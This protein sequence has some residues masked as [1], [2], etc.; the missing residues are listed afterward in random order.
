MK[1]RYTR[2]RGWVAGGC[3]ALFM[4]VTGV[5][6]ARDNS[7]ASTAGAD[8]ASNAAS[9]TTSQTAQPRQTYRDDDGGYGTY[10]PSRNSNSTLP[11]STQ[12]QPTAR[13]T[14]TLPSQPS[15]TTH[16]RTR[17]S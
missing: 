1:N 4:G 14:P 17:A 10:R 16:T 9:T 8:N 15:T 13:S 3:A 2:T 7:S 6:I 12:Q 11:P 5:L